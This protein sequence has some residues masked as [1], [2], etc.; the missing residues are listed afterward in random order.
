MRSADPGRRLIPRNVDQ[1]Q[2]FQLLALGTGSRGRAG[3][4]LVL[5]DELLELLALGQHRGVGPLVVLATFLLELEEVVDLAGKHRQLAAREIEGRFASGGEERAI[6]R[7]DQARFVIL[8][9][10]VLQQDLGAKIEEV[11]RFVEQQQVR[12]VEQERREF[13][14][15]LP[16]TGEL[17]DRTFEI[18]AFQLELTSDF[19]AL[20]I[21]LLAVTHEEFERGLSGKKRVVLSEVAEPQVG[22]AR[23]LAAIEFFL[24]E[25]NAE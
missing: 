22:M 9:E 15:G 6:V 4:G 11:R 12:I 13:Q 19:A 18:R 23:D 2:L 17:R 25:N 7:N 8:A 16:T 5:G 20:P 3:A 21:G 14:S 24:V 1:L 10:E